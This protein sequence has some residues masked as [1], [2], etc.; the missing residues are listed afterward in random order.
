MIE[1]LIALI[2]IGAVLYVVSILPIDGTIKTIIQ[3]IAV[4][5]IAIWALRHLLPLAGIS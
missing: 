1:L 3:V 4:V 5:L 2:V